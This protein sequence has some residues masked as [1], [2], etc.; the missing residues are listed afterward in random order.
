MYILVDLTNLEIQDVYY[1]YSKED[2]ID[3]CQQ[4]LNSEDENIEI[5]N[6]FEKAKEILLTR[7][8]YKVCEVKNND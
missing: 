2:I 7:F 8:K 3:T 5:I 6:N 4:N 1:L